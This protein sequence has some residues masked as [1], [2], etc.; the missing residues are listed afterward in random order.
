MSLRW[1]SANDLEQTK[2]VIVFSGGACNIRDSHGRL[3]RNVERDRINDWLTEQG[4]KFYDPQIHPDTHGCEYDFEKHHM[5]E[6]SAREHA[7]I[8]LYEISPRTFGGST[9]LE[10]AVDAFQ[11]NHPMIIFF[12]D[13]NY[14]KDVIP[15]HSSEGVPLFKPYGIND[16]D[17]ARNAHYQE[18]IKNANRMRRYLMRFAENLASLTVTFSS[19]TFQG[20]V[21]I[22]PERMHAA[23]LFQAVVKAAS[24]QRVIV[25]FMGG[26]EARDEKGNPI[27]IAP[28]NPK[29]MQL[30]TLLDQYVDEGYALRRAISQLV[31]VNVFVRVVYTQ[32]AS[33]DAIN[34]MLHIK[35]VKI[36]E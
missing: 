9:G 19:Q 34:D 11:Y 26:D 16:N 4:V 21:V 7:K 14:Q 27:F 18:F 8:N 29:E 2:D 25:N 30:R 31:R 24:G 22:T 12:S 23:D 20:D 13:G 28:E 33:I 6:M 36:A 32:R 5:L 35:G 15:A 10:I 1:N 3:L 17:M